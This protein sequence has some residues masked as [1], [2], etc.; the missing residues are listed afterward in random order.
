MKINELSNKDPLLDQAIRVFWQQWGSKEN[1]KFYEDAILHSA[2]T[3]S[4]I[5]RFYVAVEDGEI[6]GTYAIL[7]NDINSRQDLCPWLACLY[8]AEEHRG[9]GIG[10]KLLE[11][12]LSVA[13]EKGYE[14][15]YLTTDIEHYYERYGWKN[16]GIVY[17]PGGGSIKLYA[18]RT[19]QKNPG[20]G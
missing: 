14:S 2:T 3:S 16:S 17:G 12:G 18:K 13:A 5:P 19:A 9:K 4:D 20:G 10:A 8:V 11:H 6:I 15:L 1:F 7:R